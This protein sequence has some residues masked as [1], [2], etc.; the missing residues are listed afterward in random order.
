M[1]NHLNIG[2]EPLVSVI[3]VNYNGE[4][5]LGN[6]FKSLANQT[7]KS[8]EVIVI[9]NASTDKSVDI[10]EQLSL[11]KTL[12]K[13]TVFK[14]KKNVG[15]CLSNNQGIKLAVGDYVVLLNNDTIV[16]TTWLEGLVESVQSKDGPVAATCCMM[17]GDSSVPRFGIFYDIYGA[18]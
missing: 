9:D 15:F 7:L 17:N 13:V 5:Y 3:I 16:N 8:F 10:L 4:K 18:S 12:P 2:N 14:N 6:L 11:D 1:S